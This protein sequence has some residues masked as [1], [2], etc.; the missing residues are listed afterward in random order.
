MN[1]GSSL[2]HHGYAEI[3]RWHVSFLKEITIEKSISA[4]DVF[5]RTKDLEVAGNGT[6]GPVSGTPG[7]AG[8]TTEPLSAPKE[9]T[10]S[11]LTLP[12][13]PIPFDPSIPPPPFPPPPPPPGDIPPVIYYPPT[14]PQLST[15]EDT[16][17]KTQTASN[18]RW[19]KLKEKVWTKNEKQVHFVKNI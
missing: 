8:I 3:N 11:P 1:V 12:P 10:G 4:V 9:P 7:G 13:L 18:I 19:G 17:E 16:P 15:M 14:P 6:G 5:W 2:T